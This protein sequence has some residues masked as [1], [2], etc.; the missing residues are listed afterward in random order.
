MTKTQGRGSAAAPTL[1]N[2]LGLFDPAQCS[3][4]TPPQPRKVVLLTAA[5]LECLRSLDQLIEANRKTPVEIEGQER[6]VLGNLAGPD[7][8][9]P[10]PA[11]P[12]E[13]DAGRLPLRETWE[14]WYAERPK[15]LLDRDGLELLRARVWWPQQGRVWKGVVARFGKKWGDYLQFATRGLTPQPLKHPDLVGKVLDW[16]LHLHTPLGAVDFL[17]DAVE[18]SFALVP[19]EA[20]SRAVDLDNWEQRDRDWRMCSPVLCW[21]DEAFV[22][23]RDRPAAWSD[24]QLVRLWQLL[25]W[26]DQ[27]APVVAR[28]RPD[29]ASV[30]AAFKAGAATAADVYDQLLGPRKSADFHDFAHL[31]APDAPTEIQEYPALK[32]IVDRCRARVLEVEL[33]RGERPTPATVPACSLGSIYGTIMLVRLLHAFGKKPFADNTHGDGRAEV[34]TRLVCVSFPGPQET[35]I[36]FAARVKSAGVPQERLLGLAFLAPQWLPFVEHALGWPGLEDGVWWF[37]AHTPGGRSLDGA[38]DDSEAFQLPFA[39]AVGVGPDAEASSP[40]ET[41]VAERTPVAAEDLADGVVDVAWFRR[42]FE[43]LGAR[44]WAA[45]ADAAR[46]GCDGPAYETVK[47]LS[48]ALQGRLKKPAL[49]ER[50]RRRRCAEAVR[51]LGLLPMAAGDK[52]EPD[53]RVRYEVLQDFRRHA[54]GLSP[55]A[56]QSALRAY[57][58]GLENLA[59][60]AGYSNP[61]RLEWA[62]E[63]RALGELANGPVS[64]ACRDVTATL[65]LDEQ[66]RPQLAFQ[67]GGKPLKA[68]PPAVRRDAKVAALSQ[69]GAEL[70]R[71]AGNVRRHLEGAMARGDTFRGP[72]LCRLFAH[73]LLAPVL[74]RLVLL[75]EGSRGYP[76]A[77]G[78]GLADHTGRVEPVKPHEVLRIAHPHDL[79]MGGDWDRWQAECFR[80]ERVQPFKQLFRELYFPSEGERREGPVSHRY[81]GR[82]VNAGQALALLGGR[83]WK[84]EGAIS[85]S[86]HEA[87]VTAWLTFRGNR[88]PAQ[89]ETATL[90][91]VYFTRRAEGRPLGLGE[92]PTRLYSE[93]VRDLDLAVSATHVGGR[94]EASAA[95]V[96]MRAALVRETCSHLRIDNF[97]IQGGGQV[98]LTG[99]LGRYTV[100]LGSGLVQRQPGGAP[101]VVPVSAEDRARVWL[102]FAED[103]PPTVAVLAT[104]VLL[105]RDHEIR[106]PEILKLLR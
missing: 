97:R 85:R 49:V 31:T 2:G 99:R 4:R 34:L 43:A 38:S 63:T 58:V 54:Q 28:L 57:Q 9:G 72:E 62:M 86:F 71:Q 48:D 102:P 30:A 42:A 32:E 45:V 18:A 88:A 6:E 33:G 103:D 60:A 12:P 24:Q 67:R 37:L 84:V 74:E 98:L 64:A 92:V 91:G 21:L 75:G 80:R 36:D 46:F 27:P 76:V 59:R 25:H 81:A 22:W 87:G 68:V 13:E 101:A 96:E 82:Q 39:Q 23:Q 19:A 51:L 94:P 69:R 5:A 47:L 3:P 44:R 104:V 90:E 26:R 105:A 78:R 66:A 7:F 40:W 73:P 41:A 8:P 52:G 20:R 95:T 29:L 15:K 55:A 50:I 35:E 89:S 11:Q 93:V 10:D 17:L 100:Q 83:G 79:A 70:Q 77:G 16:L 65:S 14:R 61:V 1:D 106:D 53:V 56:R